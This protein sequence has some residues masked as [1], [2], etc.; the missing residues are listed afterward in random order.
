[1]VEWLFTAQVTETL[2]SRRRSR[3]AF[4]KY[5]W[6]FYQAPTRIHQNTRFVLIHV[7]HQK[8]RL[9]RS[10]LLL[11]CFVWIYVRCVCVLVKYRFSPYFSHTIRI[12]LNMSVMFLYRFGLFLTL[13]MVRSWWN[14]CYSSYNNNR[15]TERMDFT[16]IKTT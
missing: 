6:R 10:F 16:R 1:M 13:F 8:Y 2:N 12:I 4:T 5:Y 11:F 9:T 14:A 3:A 15:Y 7:W